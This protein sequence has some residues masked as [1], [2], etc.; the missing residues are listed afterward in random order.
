MEQ[1]RVG[2][3]TLTSAL[4]LAK[5]HS[6][7]PA[8]HGALGSVRVRVERVPDPYVPEAE[9]AAPKIHGNTREA[10]AGKPGEGGAGGNR[11]E[12]AA[13]GLKALGFRGFV[14]PGRAKGVFAEVN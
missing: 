3:S 5:R 4:S 14:R 9:G 7:P 8:S 11:G 2:H 6:S 10:R 1:F 12:R 13:D